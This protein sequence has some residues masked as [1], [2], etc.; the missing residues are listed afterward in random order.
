MA[1]RIL[2]VD[3]EPDVA[4]YLA[5]AL[6]VNGYDTTVANSVEAGLVEIEQARP[7]LVC[8]DI[9]MPKESGVSMYC[10]LRQDDATR[11]I[12]VIIISGA[13]GEGRFDIH[14]YPV[15]TTVPPPERFLEKPVDVDVLLKT[16]G[17][18]LASPSVDDN[19]VE[20]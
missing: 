7:D 4:T 6:R 14:A 12:P 17:D 20:R 3:D 1:A 10:R 15:D 8:L 19:E 16:V 5:T 13:V 11:D 2:I 9:M 18:L